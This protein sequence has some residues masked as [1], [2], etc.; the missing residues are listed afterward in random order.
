M[1]MKK[2]I[3]FKDKCSFKKIGSIIISLVLC[4]ITFGTSAIALETGKR[5]ERSEETKIIIPNS[6]EPKKE[7]LEKKEQ[8]HTFDYIYDGALAQNPFK[9]VDVQHNIS[10]IDK[11]DVLG[12]VT[13]DIKFKYNTDSNKAE[14][15]C[16]NQNNIVSP[17]CKVKNF[18]R[19][20][21]LT[22]DCG[23]GISS[24]KFKYDGVLQDESE[25]KYLCDSNG[26]ITVSLAVD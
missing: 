3:M 13:F 24:V 14:C 21:N 15:L 6:D 8:I 26:K 23:A 2:I 22:T 25:Y 9:Y 12:E 20:A 19:K 7:N 4:L 5:V 17:N 10:Y 11:A 1:F 16:T 18:I